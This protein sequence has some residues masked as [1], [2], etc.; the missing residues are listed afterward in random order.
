VLYIDAL[1]AKTWETGPVAKRAVYTVVRVTEDGV[2]DI[3]GLYVAESESAKFWMG[4]LED[5]KR[6]GVERIGVVAADGLSRLCEAIEAVFPT[7]VFQACVVHLIRNSARLA[8]WK[9][10][11]A[12]CADL[13]KVYTAGPEEEARREL[14]AFKAKWDAKYPM[15][16]VGPEGP[17]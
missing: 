6:R 14:A 15:V 2:K 8:P 12:L 16:A 5:L 17:G 1:F 13:R 4:V 7:A 9:D 11:K 3:L 10:R